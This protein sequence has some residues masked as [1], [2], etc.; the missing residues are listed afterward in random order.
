M[1]KGKSQEKEIDMDINAERRGET[2]L[3][4]GKPYVQR[5]RR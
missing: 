1:S 2:H 3:P 5:L 4:Y